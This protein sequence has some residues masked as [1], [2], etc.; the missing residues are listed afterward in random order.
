[1]D[2][3][4]D[5][6]KLVVQKITEFRPNP[7]FKKMLCGKPAAEHFFVCVY[8]ENWMVQWFTRRQATLGFF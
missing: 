3:V 5:A 1:M 8:W 7:Y 4:L 2:N 6:I